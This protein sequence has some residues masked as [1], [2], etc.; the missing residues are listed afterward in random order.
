MTETEIKKWIND[1]A[2][3]EASFHF[4]AKWS[5]DEFTACVSTGKCTATA[6]YSLLSEKI[7]EKDGE[8]NRLK[9]LLREVCVRANIIF[10]ERVNELDWFDEQFVGQTDLH[11]NIGATL[12]LGEIDEKSAEE[13]KKY[14]QKIQEQFKKENDI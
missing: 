11:L 1:E 14:L 3:K 12:G 10:P 7:R 8:M 4:S 9:E 6:L 2:H 13:N 5:P